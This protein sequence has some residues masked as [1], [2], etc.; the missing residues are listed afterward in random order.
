MRR[1]FSLESQTQ[2]VAMEGIALEDDEVP[3]V[4]REVAEDSA[5]IEG[6]M[7]ESQ[8]VC[9]AVDCLEDLA[10]ITDGMDEASPTEVALI[11]NTAAMAVAGTDIQ[12]EEIIP[13][14]PEV[15]VTPAVT[16]SVAV[17]EPESSDVVPVVAAESY[18][19]KKVS[20]EGFSDSLREKGRRLWENIQK[21]VKTV[22]EK[23]QTFFFK[24]SQLTGYRAKQIDSLLKQVKAAGKLE[25]QKDATLSVSSGID[26]ITTDGKTAANASDLKK[27]LVAISKAADLVLDGYVK[28]VSKR[29]ELIEKAIGEFTP[30][31]AEEVGKKLVS[32]LKSTNLPAAGG[33]SVTIDNVEMYASEPLMG[34]FTVV[35]KKTPLNDG[36]LSVA[37]SLSAMQKDGYSVRSSDAK[38]SSSS[39]KIAPLTLAEIQDILEESAKVMK[40]INSYFSGA[41]RKKA[42]EIKIKLESSSGRAAKELAKAKAS[43]EGVNESAYAIYS[44]MLNYNQA[45]CGWTNT[46]TN[47]F[48]RKAT[49]SVV[50]SVLVCKK[51]LGL[52]GVK[53]VEE[54]KK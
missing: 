12:P 8:R 18:K 32:S 45:Y 54:K 50:G 1:H 9:D 7:Q 14:L 29:G 48:I 2:T 4:E 42:V 26:S 22:W 38:S 11:E 24:M 37:V 10:V 51:A 25:L 44:A 16:D 40:T 49:A 31:K 41:E 19:T 5:E 21:W 30:E 47:A 33:H 46:A 3:V 23:I 6:E 35:S 20:M 17:T 36:V 53:A 15:E 39:A 27:G 43:N 28:A 34:G 52:Y 13:T